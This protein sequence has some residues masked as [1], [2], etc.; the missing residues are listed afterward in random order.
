MPTRYVLTETDEIDIG[1]VSCH[2]LFV[3]LFKPFLNALLHQCEF[4]GFR[5]CLPVLL[6]AFESRNCSPHS[7]V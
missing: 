2:V 6:Q 5:Q 1:L 3:K 7:G 4:W